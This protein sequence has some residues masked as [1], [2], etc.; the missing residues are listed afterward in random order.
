LLAF[1]KLRAL[2]F[3]AY[4]FTCGAPFARYN[5]EQQAEIARSLFH[6]RAGAAL[7]EADV[8]QLETLWRERC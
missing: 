7:A 3:N 8:D 2:G 4:S 6:A 1:A 5:I